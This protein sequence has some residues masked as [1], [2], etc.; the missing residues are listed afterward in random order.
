M[1][2][3]VFAVICFVATGIAIF[4]TNKG[5]IS[6]PKRKIANKQE[7]SKE[8][9]FQIKSLEDKFSFNTITINRKNYHSGK[10]IQIDDVEAFYP[11]EVDYIQISG[12]KDK[13]IQEKVN[14]EIKNTAFAQIDNNEIEE[15]KLANVSIIS[16][17]T[18]N[19]SNVLSIRFRKEIRQADY[20]W[21]ASDSFITLNFNLQTG[22]QIAFTDLFTTNAGTKNII[23]KSAY[24]SFAEQYIDKIHYLEDK[25]IWNWDGDMNK[26]D[27]SE[28]E[29]RVFKVL[30]NY[31]RF[32]QYPFYLTERSICVKIQNEEITIS[33]RDFY[34][35]IAIYNKYA[36]S[37]IF[38]KEDNKQQ[39]VFTLED[40]EDVFYRKLEKIE[41]NL[42]VD[43]KMFDLSDNGKKDETKKD[44]LIQNAEK[45]IEECKQYLS[46]NKNK[47]I[48]LAIWNEIYNDG[49]KEENNYYFGKATMS[50]EYFSSTFFNK[51][52]EWEQTDHFT[53]DPMG[54]HLITFLMDQDKNKNI[55]LEMKY[56][57]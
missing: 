48:V 20:S 53:G 21:D 22:E 16:E 12:L 31:D 29:D 17:I 38:E 23:A 34:N 41:D 6:L 45:Q 39:Y 49:E 46:K 19:F 24:N 25:D 51:A 10:K 18:G 5:I 32:N 9:I 8:D 15:K 27:Y 26:I 28:V 57:Y 7:T 3:I 54:P 4:L 36:K 13:T 37:N 11:I 55:K 50:K 1:V 40:E 56:P 35:Q 2:I 33:M 30:Q 43:I 52:L 14:A 47:S 42:F 44:E